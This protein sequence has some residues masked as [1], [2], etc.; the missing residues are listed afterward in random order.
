[1]RNMG[2]QRSPG[3][4][5]GP[6]GGCAQGPGGLDEGPEFFFG[7]QGPARTFQGAH[8]PPRGCLAK[9]VMFPGISFLGPV[10]PKNH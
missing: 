5:L 4:L 10:L 6:P 1:M 7:S 2:L 9:S 3:G 8:L